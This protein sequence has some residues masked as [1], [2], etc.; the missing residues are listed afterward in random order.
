MDFHGFP[1]VLWI[2]SVGAVVRAELRMYLDEGT[3]GA[4]AKQSLTFMVDQHQ[5]A[6]AAVLVTQGS[7]EHGTGMDGM[8][9]FHQFFLGCIATFGGTWNPRG[10]VNNIFEF[11]A[12]PDGS[13]S[14]DSRSICSVLKI[15]G[16]D[17]WGNA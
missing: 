9:N 1:V 17:Q 8:K 2:V 15:C 11:S 7:L 3:A 16:V 5:A 13:L 12:F 6:A 10:C 4:D 14:A